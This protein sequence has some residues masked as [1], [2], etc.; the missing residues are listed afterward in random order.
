MTCKQK[1]SNGEQCKNPSLNN[2]EYCYWHSEK[3]SEDEKYEHR[4]AGGKNKIIKV[5]GNFP[6]LRLTSMKDIIRLNSL[7]INKVL[8][9]ELDLRIST[10]IAYLLNLQVKC[11][12]T[13]S[14]EKRLEKVEDTLKKDASKE[15]YNDNYGASVN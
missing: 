9:N 12:E 8:S 14:I 13:N 10:G 1:K 15:F 4:S 11:I 3:I 6:E 5:N 7:M 2:D